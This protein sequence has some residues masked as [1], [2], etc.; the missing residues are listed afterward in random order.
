[1]LLKPQDLLVALKLLALKNAPWQ[2]ASL[3]ESLDMG[4]GEVHSPVMRGLRAAP[5][6]SREVST[7]EWAIPV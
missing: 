5:P 4:Q 1:M 2:Y 7:E 6:H 3:A